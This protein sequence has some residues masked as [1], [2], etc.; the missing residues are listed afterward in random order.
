MSDCRI[1][2]AAFEFEI[3]FTRDRLIRTDEQI[4][5]DHSELAAPDSST[6]KNS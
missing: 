2:E 5:L 6:S 3:P 4:H 1:R